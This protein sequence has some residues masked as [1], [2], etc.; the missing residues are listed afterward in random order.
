MTDRLDEL[1]RRLPAPVI[2]RPLDQLEPLVWRRIEQGRAVLAPP[3][4]LRLQ[5]VAAAMALLVGLALGWAMN[6]KSQAADSSSLYAS[7]AD[8]GPVGRLESGL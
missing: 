2:D 8:V 1:L 5:L 3:A 4:G 6:G 7:Y